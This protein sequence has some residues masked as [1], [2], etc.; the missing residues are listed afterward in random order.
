VVPR[1][2]QLESRVF[3]LPGVPAEMKTMF[4]TT[5]VQRILSSAGG[6]EKNIIRHHVMRFFGTGESDM[7]QLLGD[8]IARDR[9]PR[10]GIT[11]SAATISLRITSMGSNEQECERRIQ[12]T[13]EEI[14]ERAG[15]YH[16][17]DGDDFEQHHAVEQRMRSNGQSLLVIE[18]GFAAPLGDWFAQLGET[19]A[20]RGG[21]SL[22]NSEDLCRLS[23]KSTAEDAIQEW[24]HRFDAT[25]ALLVDRYPT[26]DPLD[27]HPLPAAKVKLHVQGIDEKPWKHSVTL[28]GHPSILQARIAKAGL[29]WLR[30]CLRDT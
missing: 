5:V 14:L 27:D 12:E 21:L 2:D 20:Y 24:M 6:P 29:S 26:L 4:D 9:E 23:G 13:R 10:V 17:G 8:M 22:A 28:G 16:F 3:A 1:T 11:V 25:H 15:Q 7:E 19:P 30:Q 18:L